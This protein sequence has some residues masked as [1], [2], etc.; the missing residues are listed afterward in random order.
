MK[1]FVEFL[2]IC[3]LDQREPLKK[4]LGLPSSSTLQDIVDEMRRTVDNGV[5][6]F[7]FGSDT[8]YL[9]VLKEAAKQVKLKVSESETDEVKLEQLI[10]K[11]I[12]YGIFEKLTPV[13]KADFVAAVEKESQK[14][15]GGAG[16]V[17]SG[18]VAAA[19]VAGN[20]G[21][22][23]TYILASSGL[24]AVSGAMGITLPFA[25]YTGMSTALGVV[26][27][28]VGWVGLGLLALFTV[29]GANREKVIPA[30]L[31]IAM[32]RNEPK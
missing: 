10:C 24:A 11:K 17:S 26:L 16:F 20:I 3:T 13:Q 29:G 4:I 12:I 2:R 22:F 27:G 9:D 19:L 1:K 15:I 21:G 30:V 5:A 6:S 31:C 23:S 7:L 8:G 18:G 14:Y 25:V 32:M 28:P